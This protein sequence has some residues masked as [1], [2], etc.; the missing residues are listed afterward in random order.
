M[1]QKYND[2]TSNVYITFVVIIKILFVVNDV[3]TLQL[4]KKRSPGGNS[5]TLKPR[6][7]FPC[8]L[9]AVPQ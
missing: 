3:V 2:D 1:W 8:P 4:I 7:T 9:S 5:A 6:P